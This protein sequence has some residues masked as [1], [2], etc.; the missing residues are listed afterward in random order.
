MLM[1]IYVAGS[2]R[3][4]GVAAHR[5]ILSALEA[6][7]VRGA[8]AFKGIES[9]GTNRRPSSASVVDAVADLPILIEVVDAP[10]TIESF[11]PLLDELLPEGLVTL[12]RLHV[13]G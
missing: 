2:A 10:E 11:V 7:G 4:E 13:R 1:R 6:R 8:I 12:E 3:H 5:A 9:Y